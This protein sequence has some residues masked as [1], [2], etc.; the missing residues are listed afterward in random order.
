MKRITMER[1]FMNCAELKEAFE[2]C[3]SNCSCEEQEPSSISKV[4]KIQPSQFEKRPTEDE[5]KNNFKNSSKTY[6]LA[7]VENYQKD[8][9]GLDPRHALMIF[10][11]RFRESHTLRDLSL[12]EDGIN[13]I[14][15]AGELDNESKE[16]VKEAIELMSSI[17]KHK[18]KKDKEDLVD[19]IEARFFEHYD[20]R[21]ASLFMNEVQPYAYEKNSSLNSLSFDDMISSIV[22]GASPDESGG[23]AY[24]FQKDRFFGRYAR[25]D[26]TPGQFNMYPNVGDYMNDRTSSILLIRRFADELFAKPVGDFVSRDVIKDF[27][28][29]QSKVSPRGEPI[30]TWDLWP[31]GP[32]NGEDSHPNEMW[33]AYVYLKIPIRVDTS[34]EWYWDYD[35]EIR[36]WIYLNVDP[37]GN[38]QAYLDYYGAWVES[39]LVADKVLSNL[40]DKIGGSL[41]DVAAMINPSIDLV[42]QFGPYGF[43]YFLPG[44]NNFEGDTDEDVSI[45][46]SKFIP[47][48]TAP[49]L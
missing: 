27:V 9:K 17:K 7:K 18:G 32:T 24:I 13:R 33:K 16:T 42:N 39:G 10:I 8:L 43:V 15:L 6:H 14:T 37:S 47:P 48:S 28:S 46:L 49:I 2:R 11:K 21:G 29:K 23:A 1:I 22:V 4:M 5:I 12:L 34:P 3:N 44:K 41:G 40:M 20:F 19:N 31:Q 30:I 36:Y 35:A 45:V 38:L 26:A 25:F